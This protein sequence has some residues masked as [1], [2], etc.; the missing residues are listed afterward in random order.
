MMSVMWV[1]MKLKQVAGTS[2]CIIQSVLSR[3]CPAA[4]IQPRPGVLSQSTGT[5]RASCVFLT[6]RLISGVVGVVCEDG[7]RDGVTSVMGVRGVGV[8]RGVPL[9]G[10]AEEDTTEE[11]TEGAHYED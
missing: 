7:L 9:S 4:L 5:C 2:R 3:Y 10:V 8:V 1:C 11:E 6:A